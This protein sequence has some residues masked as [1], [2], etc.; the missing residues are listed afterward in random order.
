MPFGNG[1]VE[2]GVGEGLVAEG[3]MPPFAL[4][5][6]EAA[7]EHGVAQDQAVLPLLVG[8]LFGEGVRPLAEEVEAAAH[9]HLLARG[10]VYEGQVHGGAA[11]VP[12]FAGHKPAGE[13]LL[14]AQAGVEVGAHERV[15]RIL[16]PATEVRHGALRPVGVVNLQPET[17]GAEIVADFPQG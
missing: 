8:D 15:V 16:S 5:G 3:E 7:A 14:L 13:Y 12:G 17:L 1:E 4:H 2:I 11:R 9:V 10:G 6:P